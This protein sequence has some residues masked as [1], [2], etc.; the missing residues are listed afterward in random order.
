MRSVLRR[1]RR[2]PRRRAPRC[3]I[4]PRRAAHRDQPPCPRWTAR[5]RSPRSGPHRALRDASGRREV[6][7]LRARA[8]RAQAGR[9]SRPLLD[10]VRLQER[11]VA[12]VV[13]RFAQQLLLEVVRVDRHPRAAVRARARRAAQSIFQ[14]PVGQRARSLDVR[15]E[16]R[17]IRLVLL[18]AVGGAS[19]HA[20]REAG[21]RPPVGTSPC[22]PSSGLSSFRCIWVICD[23]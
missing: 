11:L 22:S 4:R 2:G 16:H 7:I 20:A 6:M 10:D 15:R 5:S 18:R 3:C 23:G 12:A 9:T 1:A 14:R 8:R 17:R 13:H 21:R 19:P